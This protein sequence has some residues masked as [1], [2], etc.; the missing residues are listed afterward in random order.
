MRNLRRGS[1]RKFFNRKDLQTAALRTAVWKY[2]LKHD[3]VTNNT[4]YIHIT[5]SVGSED[6][7]NELT[8]RIENDGYK[9]IS[10]PRITGDGYYESCIIDPENNQIEIVETTTPP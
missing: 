2:I 4:G 10:E 9:I 8:K 6:T 1:S 5:F 7:V 3:T